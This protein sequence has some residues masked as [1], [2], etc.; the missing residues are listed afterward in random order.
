MLSKFY[1]YLV[2]RIQELE[3]RL[4][5]LI[6]KRSAQ[7]D[8]S[9]LFY[10][11]KVQ[12]NLRLVLL[13]IFS[14]VIKF[15]LILFTDTGSSFKLIYNQR[16]LQACPYSYVGFRQI[17]ARIRLFSFAGFSTTIA[18]VVIVSLL[19]NLIFGGRLPTQAAAYGWQQSDWS[20]NAS[21]S[22]MASH[23]NDGLSGRPND[24]NNWNRYYSKDANMAATTSVALTTFSTTTSRTESSNTQFNLGT[25][26][27]TW[28]AGSGNGGF[29]YP[30]QYNHGGATWEPTDGDPWDQDATAGIAISGIHCNIA[31]FT[32]ASGKTVYVKAWDGTNY[33]SVA[34]YA[35]NATIAGT[36]DASGKGYRAFANANGEGP[37]GGGAELN[38]NGGGGGYGGMGGNGGSNGFSGPSYGSS[39]APN[40]MGSA[41]GSYH[42]GVGGNGGGNIRF[43]IASTLSVDGAIKSNG[44]AQGS[45]NGAG[46]GGGVWIT[47]AA[48]SGSGSVMAKGA[49]GFGGG[50]GGGGGRIAFDGYS[51]FTL[52]TANIQVNAGLGG[53][54][55][56]AGSKYGNGS[57]LAMGG[58][59]ARFASA[60]QAGQDGK[61]L[62]QTNVDG[63]LV[64]HI[65][66]FVLGIRTVH[67]A[68]GE[69]VS[70][71]IDTGLNSQYVTV[72][73]N[74]L[75]ATADAGVT[76]QLASRATDS[77]NLSDWTFYG[78]NA[79]TT[80]AYSASTTVSAE[81]NNKKFIRYKALFNYATGTEPHLYDI[82][83]NYGVTQYPHSNLVGLYHLDG[84]VGA[85]AVANG[86]MIFDSSG[87]NNNGAVGNANG[88]GLSY[89]AGKVSQ[90]MSFDG[91]DDYVAIPASPSL[92][93]ATYNP[94]TIEAWIKTNAI[95]GTQRIFTRGQVGNH[96]YGLSVAATGFLNIGGFAGS[97]FNGTIP[98]AAGQWYHVVGVLD[99]A[100][101]KMYVNGVADPASGTVNAISGALGAYIGASW[102]GSAVSTFFNGQIDELAVYNKALTQAEVTARYN[103]GNPAKLTT[104]R[105]LTS[106]W[107]NTTDLK[108]LLSQISWKEN[109]T[110]TNSIKFQIR[111]AADSLEVPG[112]P[113]TSSASTTLFIGPDGTGNSF[114]SASSTGCSKDGVIATCNIPMALPIADGTDDQWMQYQISLDSD[115]G[116]TPS[117][118]DITIRYVV[119]NAP[120]FAAGSFT[121]VQAT[122]TPGQVF[123]GYSVLDSDTESGGTHPFEADIALQYKVGLDWVTASTT[124]LE[125]SSGSSRVAVASSTYAAY[126]I[127]WHAGQEPNF[128]SQLMPNLELRL[129]A[130][131]GE[132]A[133]NLSYATTSIMI[134]TKKPVIGPSD[135]PLAIDSRPAT[136]L[137][138]A[139]YFDQTDDSPLYYKMGGDAALTGAADWLPYVSSTTLDIQGLGTTSVYVRF[140]DEYDNYSDV[141]HVVQDETPSNIV[142]RD[143]TNADVNKYMEF[144]AW[145]AIAAYNGTFKTYQVWRGESLDA[146]PPAEY[147]LVGTTT[148]NQVSKNYYLDENVV[149]GATYF[150]KVAAEDMN[151][152]ISMFSE[153]VKDNPDG[154]GGTD[155]TPPAISNIQI[156]SSS[157]QSVTIAW[158]TDE[159]ASSYV[160]YSKASGDFST[161]VG[162]DTMVDRATTSGGTMGRHMVTVSGL[163][164][165]TTYYFQVKSIDPAT[166]V[167]IE[168]LDKANNDAELQ[169]T[170]KP[171]PQISEV[172][173][174]YTQLTNTSV[175]VKWRTDV[176]SDSVVVYSVNPNL[177]SP[178]E[179]QGLTGTTTDHEVL[180]TNLLP[181]TVYYFYVKSSR[182]VD[183]LVEE[184][185]DKNAGSSGLINYYQFET[186]YDQEAPAISDPSCQL[187]VTDGTTTPALIITATTSEPA[188]IHF[189]YG[190]ATST[191]DAEQATTTNFNIDQVVLID[192]LI[193]STTYHFQIIAQDR[194]A[195]Q[196][197]SNDYFCSTGEK[198]ATQEEVQN[199]YKAGQSKGNEE[200][201]AQ[202]RNSVQSSGGTIVIDK[203]DKL[204]PA[205]SDVHTAT[206]T[207]TSASISWVTNEEASGLVKYSSGS[208]NGSAGD[209][210]LT[211]SHLVSLSKLEPKTTYEYIVSSV[212]SSGNLARSGQLSFV[213]PDLTKTEVE[214]IASTTK[215]ETQA[216][217]EA[218]MKTVVQKAMDIVKNIAGQVSLGSLETTLISNY[219]TLDKLAQII[220]APVLGGEPATEI[221]PTT[222]NISWKTDKL[223]NSMVAYAPEGLYAPSKGSRGYL[224]LVGEP[225]QSA[226]DHSVKIVGL[227]PDTAYHYQ[228][229][230]KAKIGAEAVS[231]DFVFRTR[232]EALEIISVNTET[233]SKEKARF[234]WLTSQET[235]TGLSY[236]PYR[237]GK[238]NPDEQKV[239]YDKTLTTSHEIVV[240]DLEAGVV[241]QFQITATDKKGIKISKPISFFSTTKDD[242]PPEISDI[243]TESA[244]SQSKEAKVQTIITWT[245]NE[246]TISQVKFAKG[247]FEDEK[248]LNEETPIEAVYSRKHTIVVTKFEIGEVYS[249][250]VVATDSGGNQSVSSPHIVLTPKQKEGVFEL[251]INTFESTF[252]W[253][254]KMK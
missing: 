205:I 189:A 16:D 110:T 200:G 134:D 202:G 174:D 126:G 20:G 81:H 155:N 39:T 233:L 190:L 93:I 118:D 36:L 67:A 38:A 131:D 182:V 173:V 17:Q 254:G 112:S 161:V 166:N 147:R 229:R 119:N 224:Q 108:N 42:G 195:N 28:V 152:N 127:I 10:F 236:A 210:T 97:N 53:T 101:T 11:S 213:T 148:L 76:F 121:A 58:G 249:F 184:A 253:L 40:Q 138:A 221:T 95:G 80:G 34:I 145:K 37:G 6:Q 50:G 123:I 251:I 130:N 23:Q 159:L 102:S 246:P 240:S 31:N 201:Q 7:A 140:K 162:Y 216:D 111:T 98:I 211:R 5:G 48:V 177:T 169:F 86:T 83:I 29:V 87:R 109:S 125:H 244:L 24:R 8:V 43:N 199:A 79:S 206:L 124:L 191:Y 21:T 12:L 160:G 247:V 73:L 165:S 63:S 144:V 132:L 136:G 197:T 192:N 252:G 100:N 78:P 214:L 104:G 167:G 13:E 91:I 172:K 115:G 45:Y 232:P 129:V 82:T 137:P 55:A 51:T 65:L 225:N 237:D 3:F 227:R 188:I 178:A 179:I 234:S 90:A 103:S 198:L 139:V 208:D 1:F 69:F 185:Y 18:L 96:G 4:S 61:A 187:T 32:I 57:P 113:S 180:L 22:A 250:R 196:R 92:N 71:A 215:A 146:N 175:A 116:I 14:D 56:T 44:T 117:V 106:S 114:F 9:G 226:T 183:G 223:A 47:A 235:D 203:T 212:D 135:Q 54:G 168:N 209:D 245:T 164:P 72:T 219:D 89:Q 176:D 220:P 59:Q 27:N 142:I 15:F 141:F 153:T 243:Q 70:T 64:K 149:A 19:T 241:Y 158:D 94:V 62:S 218:L 154:Q 85:G 41:G 25:T 122:S 156:V 143:L 163:S 181:H 88:N 105:A 204:P 239:V 74:S 238:L 207:A 157:T 2:D 46:A 217:K 230:S 35:S 228:L 75:K 242:L 49:D 77:P 150:Y 52:P 30:C 170:T 107:Y 26:T 222:V 133:N 193:A 248:D 128:N 33:G 66:F 68:T 99:G 120:E 231:R 60:Y 151:G 186:T 171:G 84:D 194:S